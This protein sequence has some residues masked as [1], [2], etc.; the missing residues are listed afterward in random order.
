MPRSTLIGTLKE[1]SL[2][3]AIK[4]SLS[5]PG[6]LVEQQVDGYQ[7]DIQRGELLIEIQTANFSSLKTKLG[8]LL[9]NYRVLLVHPIAETKWI[10]KQNK[11]KREISRRK[12]P[13]RGR[14]EHLFDELLS[15]PQ[16]AA[17]PNFAFMV[18]LTEVEEIWRNDGRGSWRRKHWSIVDRR[19]VEIIGSQ[20]FESPKDYLNLL[21]SELPN[22]FTHRQ[23]AK[24]I[25]APVWTST[26]MSYCLRKMGCLETVGKEGRSLLLARPQ[27]IDTISAA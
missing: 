24:A 9:E 25:G 11:R 10:V 26:R 6:D 12:S 20:Y 5:K 8:K 15:I 1:H 23:L 17:H 18:L 13:K 21:P 14:V 3:A 27:A 19:L 2:H 7:I 16:L 22:P 4:A